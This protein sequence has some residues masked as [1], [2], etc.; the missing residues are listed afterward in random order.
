MTRARA[1]LGPTLRSVSSGMRG[2]L[3]GAGVGAALPFAI[4]AWY[5]AGPTSDAYF[6]VFAAAIFVGAPAAAAMEAAA[7][8]FV[9][10]RRKGGRLALW[11]L[12]NR[13][14]AT[15]ALGQIIL[16]VSLLTVASLAIGAKSTFSPL[17]GTPAFVIAPLPALMTLSGVSAAVCYAFGNFASPSYLLLWRSTMALIAAAVFQRSGEVWPVAAGLVL[18]EAIRAA[19][20]RRRIRRIVDLLPLGEPVITPLTR[21]WKVARPHALSQYLLAVNPL[22]DRVVAASLGAGAVTVVELAEKAYYAPTLLLTTVVSNVSAAKWAHLVTD[23]EYDALRNDFR[24]TAVAGVAVASGAALVG[25]VLLWA[26]RVPIAHVLGLPNERVLPLT[27]SIYLIG[28]PV[29][30]VHA[31]AIRVLVAMKSTPILFRV[32]IPMVLANVAGD[33]VAARYWGIY[34][35]AG[36]STLVLAAATTFYVWYL[37]TSLLRDP[38]RVPRGRERR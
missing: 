14:S 38:E 16:V 21:V 17:R 18:G 11:S 25:A 29:G 12:I 8:P 35:I 5:G 33:L 36:V 10:E 26:A 4:T 28:L 22:A 15:A 6:L 27:V 31:L 24:K 1:L 34:G 13:L 9:V 20:L 19:E 30:L 3:A 37:R 23:G 32:S 2:V 7:I